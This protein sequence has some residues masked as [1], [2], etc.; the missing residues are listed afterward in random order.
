M[1]DLPF[2][3]Y[4][5]RPAGSEGFHLLSAWRG[6]R[7]VSAGI[8]LTSR[9]ITLLAAGF[10]V[11]TLGAPAAFAEELA[12]PGYRH[13]AGTFLASSSAAST[14]LTSTATNARIGE[15][16][17]SLGASL[18][19]GPSGSATSLAS[20]LLG[21]WAVVVG[22]LP[23]LDL[24]GDLAQ[25]FLD[26]DDD[27]DGL[28][29]VYETGTGI[30]ISN[31]NTGSSPV[32]SD[33]DADGFADGVEVNAGTDPNDDQSFPA[34]NPAVPSFSSGSLLLLLTLLWIVAVRSALLVRRRMNV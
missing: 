16:S 22:A 5:V 18:S 7:G 17:A 24:D 33:S 9:T 12:S 25:F 6:R 23:S 10:V 2:G 4:E 32:A 3:K 27:G 11:F 13:R 19:A 34:P 28:L 31:L 26:E 21:Y 15:V 8:V 1:A 14:A 29:D 20:I 30:F